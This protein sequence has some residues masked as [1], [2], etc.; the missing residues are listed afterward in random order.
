MTARRYH[1]R[2]RVSSTRWAPGRAVLVLVLAGGLGACGPRTGTTTPG[3]ESDDDGAAGLDPAQLQAECDRAFDAALAARTERA[4]SAVDGGAVRADVL[5]ALLQRMATDARLSAA[6]RGLVDAVVGDPAI[7]QQLMDALMQ[8]ASDFGALVSLGSALL[9]GGGDLR[10][11]AERA[12][13]GSLGA[14]VEAAERAGLGDRLLALPEVRT[15][16]SAL[17]PAAPFAAAAAGARDA[18]PATRAAQDARLRLVVPGDPA[19]TREAGDRWAAQPAGVGCQPVVRSFPFGTATAELASVREAAT[20]AAEQLLS[21]PALREETVALARDLMADASFRLAL[22]DLL[23]RVLRE[24]SHA[25]LVEA[26]LPVLASA[27]VP[28]AAAAWA[29]RV[30]GRRGELPDLEAA[31]AAVAADPELASLLLRFLDVLVLSEGCIEL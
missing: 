4:L 30:A 15:L 20:V 11:R 25:R 31:L 8:S 2:V 10:A 24:E 3:G 19:A 5:A 21:T 28:Q 7:R 6:G 26:A 9:S 29:V 22:D 12:L 27:A 14:L 17:F 13:E 23:V 16:L 1:G 18:L